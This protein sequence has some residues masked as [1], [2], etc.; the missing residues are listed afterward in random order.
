MQNS[1]RDHRQAW[2]SLPHDLVLP[3]HGQHLE[4][5]YVEGGGEEIDVDICDESSI[6]NNCYRSGDAIK[7]VVKFLT[8]CTT[9]GEGGKVVCE[10]FASVAPLQKPPDL[11]NSMSQKCKLARSWLILRS[12]SGRNNWRIEVVGAEREDA[13]VGVECD[14]AD[15]YGEV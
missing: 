9:G 14:F 4:S 6:V 7:H 8:S 10:I 12:L 1:F 2:I 5:G 13:V 11:G 3:H 15:D